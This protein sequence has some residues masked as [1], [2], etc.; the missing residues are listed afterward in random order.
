MTEE[1]LWLGKTWWRNRSAPHGTPM[2]RTGRAARDTRAVG[3]GVA[4]VG[5]ARLRL[6]A[7]DVHG[8]P[9]CGAPRRRRLYVE[10]A[11]GIASRR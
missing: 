10:G 6:G 8:G 1:T 3:E 2:A 11:G 9:S 7:A 4:Q 5:R